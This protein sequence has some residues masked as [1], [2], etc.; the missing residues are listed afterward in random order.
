MFFQTYTEY[1][2]L[3]KLVGKQVTSCSLFQNQLSDHKYISDTPLP[4][5]TD[6]P[7]CMTQGNFKQ[8]LS[9]KISY[10]K[11]ENK[12]L[13]LPDAKVHDSLSPIV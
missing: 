11:I 12:H 8:Q 13:F 7:F 4:V 2:L 9:F 10:S 5:L 6:P 3:Q 1:F